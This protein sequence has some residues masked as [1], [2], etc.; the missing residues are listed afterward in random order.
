MDGSKAASQIGDNSFKSMKKKKTSLEKIS[1]G[2]PQGSILEP[3]LFLLY[4]NNLKNDS[5]ILDPKMFTDDTNLFL[6]TR[7]FD[8]YFK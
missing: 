2:V 8:I 5:N 1:Y 3:L 6:H 7:I 4:E